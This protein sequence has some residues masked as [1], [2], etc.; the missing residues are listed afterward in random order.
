MGT[1]LRTSLRIRI[2]LWT[3]VPSALIMFAVAFT[4]YH[5]YQSVTRELVVGRNQQLTHLSA[6]KLSADLISYVNTLS[7]LARSLDIYAGSSARQSAALTRAANQL[8]VFD[9]GTLILDPLGKIVATQPEQPELVGQDWSDRAFFRQI[10]R[11]KAPIFSDIIA[12]GEDAPEIL[13]VAVPINDM[14]GEFRGTLVGIFRLGASSSSAFYGGI[15]KLRLG[16]S[17][18][19]YLVDSTGRVIYD[20]DERRIGDDLHA[21][22][23][24]QETL[25]GQVGYLRTRNLEGLDILA[26]FAPVPGTSWGLINEESWAGL[27]ASSRG[28]GQFL[29]LLL[30]LGGIIPTL[31]AMIGAKRITDPVAQLMAA[32]QEIAGGKYGKQINVHTGDELEALGEQFNHMSTQLLESYV[33][34]EGRVAAR[35]KELAALNATA[36]VAS[37]SLNL[38]EILRDA[39]DKTLEV[40]GMEL[41]GAYAIEDHSLKLVAQRNLSQG[42]VQE[43]SGRPLKGSIVEQAASSRQPLVWRIEDFP[44]AQMKPWLEKEQIEQAICV[45]LMAKGKLAGAFTLGTRKARSITPEELSLLAAIGQQIG[46]A[47]QNANLYQQAEETAAIAER[48]RLARDLHDAVTQ[49]LFSASLIAEV[50]PD[51]WNINQAE[52][53]RRLEELRELTRGSLAEMRTLLVEL[54]PNALT[55]IPLA[56]L[57]RQLCESLI[58]RARLPIQCSVEGE[59]RL[60]PEVQISL[61]RIAQEALNNVV[62]HS[63]ATQ[64]AVTLRLDG[65]VRLSIADDGCG[66]DPS[67]VSPDHL[68][69]K[70]MRERAEAIS[71]RITIHSEPSEGTQISV[72]WEDTR[73]EGAQR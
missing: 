17:G 5:A 9:G 53:L 18:R 47:V 50:L 60:P 55:E 73:Q 65:R 34:L 20:P 69:L 22:V 21:Q 39:L 11:S 23:D 33:Q 32:A 66:F 8:V 40:L 51:L 31:V 24:V 35:T 56:D 64:V 30:A 61:Y 49:T 43:A 14:E 52:G 25:K 16:D 63:K 46:V 19:T 1:M 28:Y 70:I 41:G 48:T 3:F 72:V 54:R 45:P 67:T 57:L 58:G 13:A 29:Y 6:G 59:K 7:L 15:V 37:R 38:E 10:L 44:E 71:A 12:G 36:A 42:F 62:K 2:I 4:I 26:T 68:G 27:L